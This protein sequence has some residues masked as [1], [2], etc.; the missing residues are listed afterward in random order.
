MSDWDFVVP[1]D[2][3]GAAVAAKTTASSTIVEMRPGRMGLGCSREDIQQKISEN[4]KKARLA[5]LL[6]RKSADSDDELP[7]NVRGRVDSDVE[8]SKS[9]VKK[10]RIG[11]DNTAAA[12]EQF[13]LN[14]LT[15]NQR[16]RLK[17]KQKGIQQQL[18][19]H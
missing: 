12:V 8:Q 2:E 11:V 10:S 18:I 5:K 7:P 14:S 16:K 6:G 1:E 13:Q 3:G 15:K 19:N 4:A 17:R 9:S